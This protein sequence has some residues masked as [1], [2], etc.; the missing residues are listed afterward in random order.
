MLVLTLRGTPTLYNGDELGAAG[1]LPGVSRIWRTARP[2]TLVASTMDFT[3]T[4]Q[5]LSRVS[6]T[7]WQ[8]RVGSSRLANVRISQPMTRPLR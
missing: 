3:L 4:S 8:T 1:A 2:V 6:D 5:A 7:S